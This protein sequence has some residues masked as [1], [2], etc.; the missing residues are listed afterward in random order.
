MMG[1]GA[2]GSF[3]PIKAKTQ[4]LKA[5]SSPTV[6]GFAGITSAMKLKLPSSSCRRCHSKAIHVTSRLSAM[7][8]MMEINVPSVSL[9]ANE[10]FSKIADLG[11]ELS[12]IPGAG[13]NSCSKGEMVVRINN[14]TF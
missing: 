14:C 8:R 6:E 7:C 10:W 13:Q 2:S 3:E 1:S 11:D 5:K 9:H 4:L 12:H